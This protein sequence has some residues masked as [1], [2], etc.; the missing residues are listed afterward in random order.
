MNIHVDI[1]YKIPLYSDVDITIKKGDIINIIGENGSGKSTFYKT[2]I[3]SIPPLKGLIP[4]EIKKNIAT[5]SDYIS[6]P[7]ELKVSDVLKFIGI[8]KV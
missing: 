4:E 8:V 7:N 2:L 5:I 1:G 6:I 3:G